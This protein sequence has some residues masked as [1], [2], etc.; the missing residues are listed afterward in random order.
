MF[1]Y[2]PAVL[3]SVFIIVPVL[4]YFL[5]SVT[6]K[7]IRY[8]SIMLIEKVVKKLRLKERSIKRLILRILIIL[9]L[10]TAFMQP[11][12]Q[13]HRAKRLPAYVDV[14]F[15]ASRFT[16]ESERMVSDLTKKNV[17]SDVFVFSSSVER[18]NGL[19]IPS[20][21]QKQDYSLLPEDG[22]YL[23]S[24][25]STPYTGKGIKLSHGSKNNNNSVVSAHF[26]QETIR[27]SENVILKIMLK[28]TYDSTETICS[29]WVNG[30]KKV[31]RPVTI[32]HQ[33]V[34]E[35]PLF[36]DTAGDYAIEIRLSDDTYNADNVYF[37]ALSVHKKK[38]RYFINSSNYFLESFFGIMES[39]RVSMHDADV[40]VIIAKNSNDIRLFQSL[41][42]EK[43]VFLFA[44][45]APIDIPGK[46][47]GFT[48]KI[49]SENVSMSNGRQ[50]FITNGVVIRH[51]RAM[52]HA[53]I[54]NKP[55]I[56]QDGATIY[57]GFDPI[58]SQ[59][60]FILQ[61]YFYTFMRERMLEKSIH[62]NYLDTEYKIAVPPDA[63]VLFNGKSIND[64]VNNG[65]LLYK[66]L[67]EPG[68]I[69]II[70]HNDR[71]VYAVNVHPDEYSTPL[72]NSHDSIFV[73]HKTSLY[74]LFLML[75]AFFLTYETFLIWKERRGMVR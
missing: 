6:S 62:M 19:S 66:D 55:V 57:F 42:G 64:R 69:Y 22:F 21:F 28:S 50:F 32:I 65:V 27:E 2:L 24:D 47:V 54:H 59:T 17:F 46:T 44:Q 20:T 60:D 31:E 34:V 14:S 33:E 73:S 58:P 1:E 56:V 23:I 72:I 12:F 9:S 18:L 67:H 71:R 10:V 68:M 63:S 30:E 45:N 11:I 39:E 35:I 40:V 48:E 7:Q 13:S 53:H 49:T 51:D 43:K 3:L 4:L 70:T 36:F 29:V 15:S 61:P 38:V 26:S 8:P 74:R 5:R 16:V 52:I 41:P 75:T 37:T 25:F